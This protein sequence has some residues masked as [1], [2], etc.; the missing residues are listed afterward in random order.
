[1]H[2]CRPDCRPFLLIP[3]ITD[4]T[5]PPL[6]LVVG[7]LCEVPF[8]AR[9]IPV[10]QGV[11]ARA[12]EL[13]ALAR[14]EETQVAPEHGCSMYELVS[15]KWWSTV[16]INT[17]PTW[18]HL[19]VDY[20]GSQGCRLHGLTAMCVTV[21]V[22]P[23]SHKFICAVLATSDNY[24]F[25]SNLQWSN[26]SHQLDLGANPPAAQCTFAGTPAIVV[27]GQINGVTLPLG[28]CEISVPLP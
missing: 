27:E 14:G 23:N 24:V 4:V 3:A 10:T 7:L 6:P 17:G 5:T 19:T 21:V 15:H 22:P 28:P 1:M 13:A 26:T 25:R 2:L 20:S 16:A 9:L 8:S 12:F 11:L 18:W